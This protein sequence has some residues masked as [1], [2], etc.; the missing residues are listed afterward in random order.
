MWRRV[1]LVRTTRRNIPEEG[2]LQEGQL[3]YSVEWRFAILRATWIM[4]FNVFAIR[5]LSDYMFRLK[6]A[7]IKGFEFP[8]MYAACVGY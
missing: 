1:A 6:L 8:N 3:F 7:I 5:T 2:M 4:F